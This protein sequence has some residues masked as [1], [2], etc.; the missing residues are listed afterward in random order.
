MEATALLCLVQNLNAQP[1]FSE[2]FDYVAGDLYQQQPVDESYQWM[3]YNTE[4]KNAIKVSG[5]SLTFAVYQDAAKGSAVTL[6]GLASGSE[7]LVAK[8]MP[9]SNVVYSG[10][11]YYSALINVSDVGKLGK[12]SSTNINYFLSLIQ[13]PSN[14]V[15]VAS[16]DGVMGG[17]FANLFIAKGE[18]DQTFKLGV[19]RRETKKAVFAESELD[20]ATTYLVVVCYEFIEG[21]NNDKVALFINPTSA[22]EE[23][24]T[25]DA[26]WSDAT[27]YDVSRGLQGIELRQGYKSSSPAAATFVL[28]ELR[29]ATTRRDLF[30]AAPKKPEI[31]VSTN[32]LTA[33]KLRTCTYVPFK[34]NVRATD[35]EGDITVSQ[36]SKSGQV[37]VNTTTISNYDATHT[38]GEFLGYDLIVTIKPNDTDVIPADEITL[39]ADGADP[40]TIP[41]TWT[42][43]TEDEDRRMLNESF[44]YATGALLG[45]GVWTVPGHDKNIPIRVADQNLTFTGYQDDAI[46]R[47]VI[48]DN[49]DKL[50]EDLVAKFTANPGEAVI[51]GTLYYSAIIKVDEVSSLKNAIL[52][53]GNYILSLVQKPAPTSDLA[54]GKQG[55]E[56]GRLFVMQGSSDEK[57]KLGV[58][59]YGNGNI[60]TDPNALALT[61]Q[62]YGINTP[63]LVVVKYEFVEGEQNDIVSLYVNPTSKEPD[64]ADAIYS[65]SGG[66]DAATDSGIQGIMLRQGRGGNYEAPLVVVDEL[67]VAQ[68]YS[69]LFPEKTTV[70]TISLD[71]SSV[72]DFEAKVGDRQDVIIKVTTKDLTDYGTVKVIQDTPGIFT[73]STSMLL[74]NFTQDLKITFSPKAAETYNARIEF[75]SPGAETVSLEVTGKGTADAGVESLSFSE[76]PD[77]VVFD[78]AGRIVKTVDRCANKQQLYQGLQSGTYVVEASTKDAVSTTKIIVP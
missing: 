15:D 40:V 49:S 11:L 25:P 44:D 65:N 38:T 42:R 26:V 60:A 20:L 5:E 17:E 69:D 62:E 68:S 77:V 22:T 45:K 53:K 71:P 52:T 13:R 7:D 34:I 29:L 32:Y 9:E 43:L 74:K 75:S 51:D 6:A 41:I 73:V 19:T 76:T 33:E 24:A 47:S 3:K 30:P 78:L 46:G 28:D 4:S 56:I 70:P 36:P 39:T 64:K 37:S 12:S 31:I 61:E 18:S 1:L 54:E 50:G 66:K 58:N 21:D 8:F 16:K 48:L 2:S 63:L 72:P 55:T 14:T 23:P 35:L 67:R 59:R 27:G 10:K 57:F